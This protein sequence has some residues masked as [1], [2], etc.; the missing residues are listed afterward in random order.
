[1]QKHKTRDLRLASYLWAQVEYPVMFDGVTPIP[2]STNLFYFNFSIEATEEQLDSMLHDYK[3][4]RTCV[5]P[6]SYMAKWGRLKD[7]LSQS[8]GTRR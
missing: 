1:M 2:N 7:T 3:N 5:E 6:N 4:E 8:T